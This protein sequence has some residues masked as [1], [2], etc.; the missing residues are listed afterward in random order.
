MNNNGFAS[1]KETENACVCS[2]LPQFSNGTEWLLEYAYALPVSMVVAL[3]NFNDW[4]II[5]VNCGCDILTS[6]KS[7]GHESG[8]SAAPQSGAPLWTILIAI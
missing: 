7:L 8:V 2:F 1:E 5:Y 6:E 4:W 3:G